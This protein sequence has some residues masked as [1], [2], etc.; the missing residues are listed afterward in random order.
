M[1]EQPLILVFVKDLF[2]SVRIESAAQVKDFQVKFIESANQISAHE[3]KPVGRQFAEPLEGRDAILVDR[4]TQWRP[5]L[6]VFDLGN[7]SIP[8]KNWINLLT[9]LPAT[10]RIPVLCFGSH[11]NIDDMQA[12]KLAG[13][14]EVVARSRF[15]QNLPDLLVKH[16]RLIDQDLLEGSCQ[17]SLSSLAVQGMEQFNGGKYFKAHESLENA[18]LED[19][20]PGRDLYQA[21]LQIAVAYYQIMR[22]N[23][24]GAAKMFLRVRQWIEPLPDVCRGVQVAKLRQDAG[25][26]HQE[27]LDLGPEKISEFDRSLLKPVEYKQIN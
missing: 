4:I 5:V 25:I 20:T 15:V 17:S 1:N 7:D 22:G 21:V 26:V 10:R 6:I 27:L 16:A 12:A 24:K 2:F 9:S 11:V 23:Y 19:Q 13:A 18:W 8:W 3:R 14:K